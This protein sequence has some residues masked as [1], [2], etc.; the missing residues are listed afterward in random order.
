MKKILSLLSG[1]LLVSQVAF[2]TPT[3]TSVVKNNCGNLICVSGLITMDSSYPTGGETITPA[4]IGMSSISSMTAGSS[5]YVTDYRSTT[6]KLRFYQSSGGTLS[7]NTGSTT[8]TNS[9][10]AVT[11]TGA[12][13]AT[14]AITAG[15]LNTVD[16]ATPGGN[17]LY[18]G[19]VG[20]TPVF[21]SNMATSI[22]D[23]ILVGT[24][25]AMLVKYSATPNV[26]TSQVYFKKAN[27][28]GQRMVADL[29]AQGAPAFFTVQAYSGHN[30]RVYHDAAANTGAAI[31]VDD[32][33][34]IFLTANLVGG[35][36]PNTSIG[37]WSQ[38]T[39]DASA[40]VTVASLSGTAA[41][42]VQASH[43]HTQSGSAAAGALSEVPNATNLSTVT[44][45]FT[46]YGK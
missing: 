25:A 3:Y 44:V 38:S 22:A 18:V 46:A 43:L 10:S 21:V 31:S 30:F 39:T 35:D 40:V 42:Q 34:Q 37:G 36:L 26:D 14:V 27:P 13:T 17:P 11:G 5:G 24:G 41:A 12:G 8:A 4:A 16:D 29:T 9:S 19:Q 15:A 6:Q 28:D 33:G 2:A 23:Q 32:T 7:G 20:L 1:F 45:P